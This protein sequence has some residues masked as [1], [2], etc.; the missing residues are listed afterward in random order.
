MPTTSVPLSPIR[1]AA[2]AGSVSPGRG[3]IALLRRL[4]RWNDRHRQRLD[5]A[6]LDDR[7]LQD[8]GITRRMAE[9]ECRKPPWR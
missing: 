3:V 6:D 1:S 4:W 9:R 7:M 5:L 2:E 8:I